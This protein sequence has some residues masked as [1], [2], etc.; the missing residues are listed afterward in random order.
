MV[1]RLDSQQ[2]AESIQA[3]CVASAFSCHYSLWKA[4]R[5]VGKN[6]VSRRMRITSIRLGRQD[7]EILSFSCGWRGCTPMQL[8]GVDVFNHPVC[9]QVETP[10]GNGNYRRY[11]SC[12][13]RLWAIGP[14][15]VAICLV[16]ASLPRFFYSLTCHQC[17]TSKRAVA[18]KNWLYTTPPHTGFA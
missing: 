16:V 7:G 18:F 1:A 6:Q 11:L 3:T 4:F 8:A 13:A 5:G 9:E 17:C 2:V 10:L 15:F 12:K 14:D